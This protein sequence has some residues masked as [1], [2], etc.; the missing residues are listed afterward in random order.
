MQS[1]SAPTRGQLE[2]AVSQAVI[3]FKRDAT[4]RGPLDVRTYLLDDVALVRLRGVLTVAERSLAATAG[5]GPQLVKQM[6]QELFDQGRPLLIKAVSEA[7]GVEVRGLYTDCD[8]AADERVIV[9]SLAARPLA[10]AA[11]A[12]RIRE[13]C[14]NVELTATDQAS[15]ISP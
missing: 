5:R 14:P 2:A 10:A 8:V 6:W 12:G 15:M 4:G 3:R 13:K 1:F 9:F 7:L 11:T